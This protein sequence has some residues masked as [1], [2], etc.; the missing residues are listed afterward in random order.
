M[1]KDTQDIGIIGKGA[2]LQSSRFGWR[3][4]RLEEL[5]SYGF[6]NPKA[7]AISMDAVG[8]LSVSNRRSLE[9]AAAEFGPHEL[10]AVRPSPAQHSWNGVN[11]FFN[12]GVSD[13]TLQVIADSVG[14]EVAQT[15]YADFVEAYALSVAMLPPAPFAA[16]DSAS[17]PGVRLRILLDVYRREKG[18]PFPQDTMVQLV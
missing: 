2:A 1:V 5:A 8:S 10:L 18:E 17:A 4:E 16:A 7:V 6:P 3:A 12:I 15:I 9:A 11:A 14:I 13:I